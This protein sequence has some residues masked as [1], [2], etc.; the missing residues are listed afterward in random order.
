MVGYDIST[1]ESYQTGLPYSYFPP[2]WIAKEFIDY[3]IVAWFS[4]S[5]NNFTYIILDA[6]VM[7]ASRC[8][9]S[10]LTWRSALSLGKNR[11]Q[12][13]RALQKQIVFR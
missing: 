13:L 5:V 9:I 10:V 3:P 11:K 1:G 2:L 4:L 6:N 12:Q 8:G 7:F